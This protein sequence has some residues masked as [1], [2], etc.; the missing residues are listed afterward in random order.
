MIVTISRGQQITIPAKL[1]SAL[2]LKIGSK[3][4]IEEKDNMLLIKPIGNELEKMFEKTK[5]IQPK[6]VLTAQE[7]DNYNEK[8]FR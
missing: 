1:R 6:K 7:M 5:H 8:M 4:E 3:V 2:G